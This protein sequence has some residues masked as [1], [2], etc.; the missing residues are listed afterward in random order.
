[1]AIPPFPSQDLAKL[2]LGYLAEEQLMTAYDEFL[3]AS[4]YLDALRN[5]YDRIL[6]TSLKHILAEYRAVKIYVETC[7][8]FALRKKLLQCYNLLEMVKFLIQNVDINKLY[9]QEQTTEKLSFTKN[10]NI[11]PPSNPVQPNPQSTSQ[12]ENSTLDSSVETTSLEDLPGNST[13]K[14]KSIKPFDTETKNSH[15]NI[16]CESKICPVSP[17]NVNTTLLT[18]VK[19]DTS[20]QQGSNNVDL[21]K[22]IKSESV[23]KIEEFNNILDY[24]CK[25]GTEQTSYPVTNNVTNENQRLSTAGTFQDF[26]TGIYSNGS[27][28]VSYKSNIPSDNNAQAP[29]I[30]NASNTY[31]NIGSLTKEELMSK[32]HLVLTVDSSKNAQGFPLITTCSPKITQSKKVNA[33]KREENKIK[34]LSDVI[35]D[36]SYESL[37]GKQKM[38]PVLSNATSTPFQ[39]PTILINGTPAYK[40]NVKSQC[41]A[42]L[43]YTSDEIMAM[44]TIILVPATGTPPSS[45]DSATLAPISV[46]PK[47]L[48]VTSSASQDLLKPLLIDVTS[49]VIEPPVNSSNIPSGEQD[50]QTEQSLIKT[51]ESTE[52]ILK[53][54]ENP[55]STTTTST[56][57][58]ATTPQGVFPH[59]KSSSTPRRNSHVRVLDFTT[60]RRILTETINE[61]SPED[62]DHTEDNEIVQVPCKES[63]VQVDVVQE[64]IINIENTECPKLKS[65][66]AKENKVITKKNWDADIRAAAVCGINTPVKS[67]QKSKYKTKEKAIK[68]KNSDEN[69]ITKKRANK[70]TSKEKKK[71]D[72]SDSNDNIDKDVNKSEQSPLV[73]KANVNIRCDKSIVEE[74]KIK[75]EKNTV[76]DKQ[77]ESKNMTEDKKIV[78]DI[79]PVEDRNVNNFYGSVDRTETPESERIALQNV[80]GAKLNIS[81]LL[82]TPYKQ[83][84]YDIQMDTPK[85]LGTDLPDEPMSEVKIMSIPTPRFLR[86]S[87]EKNSTPSCCY[88]S[89]QTDYSSGGSYY[90]PDDQDFIICTDVPESPLRQEEKIQSN[91]DITSTK[92]PEGDIEKHKESKSGRPVRQC[93]KNVSYKESV[94]TK[95]TPLESSE[96]SCVIN[97]TVENTLDDRT[98]TKSSKD[99]TVKDKRKDTNKS[100]KPVKKI[101]SPIKRET[102]KTFMKIKPRRTTPIK[103]VLGGKTRKTSESSNK[104]KKPNSKERNENLTPASAS[105]PT[106]SRRKSSTPRKLHCT[107][108][109]NSESS[110][111]TSPETAKPKQ[112]KTQ[113]VRAPSRES[114]IEQKPLTWSDDG[115]Q[116][117]TLTQHKTDSVSLTDTDDISKIKEYIETCTTDKSEPKSEGSLHYDLIKRGFDVE[118]AKIIE[119]DLLDSPCSKRD[120][121]VPTESNEIK[122]QVAENITGSGDSYSLKVDDDDDEEIELSIHECNEDTVNYIHYEYNANDKISG[123]E[124]KLKDNYSMEICVDDGVTIRLRATTFNVLLDQDPQ[125]MVNYSYKET[126]MAVSSISNFD[127]LYTPLKDHKAQMYDIFDSTLTSLDTPLKPGSPKSPECERNNI[128]EISLEVEKVEYVEK[129]D[130]KKR[131]RLQSGSSEESINCIKKTKRDTQY[132]LNTTNIQNIDIESVLSKLHGP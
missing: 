17:A 128:T 71:K 77:V 5:E 62:P 63:Q 35:V 90:K 105:I 57:P 82:E 110:N 38:P 109:F 100:K 68:K 92:Q 112:N 42:K 67:T 30:R 28:Q 21:A 123:Q 79:K 20:N 46:D 9:E 26:A 94:P 55:I 111:H 45:T 97:S 1:M 93:R 91:T 7:K 60:P 53:S 124:S 34:I 69:E 126:E 12:I 75:E 8:P 22:C 132:L 15:L 59:R 39:M 41:L 106:K 98:T 119:R 95:V 51:V 2:V 32:G 44:P 29:L 58:K 6:M 31:V 80:I 66:A 104:Q 48:T 130:L 78:E 118:T 25:T 19:N 36:K 86:D 3:Q 16:D 27:V 13:I 10:V 99:A 122:I 73:V 84:L 131:K 56:L 50:I 117:E 18:E 81:D 23:Q 129:T 47:P 88:S 102:P 125:E 85:F 61:Q 14:K 114:D 33:R 37:S 76:E 65:N 70:D 87:N 54:R 103:E 74:K 64:D 127:K 120:T 96:Q 72:K 107:K 108:I 116:D 52:H 24:V 49:P 101:K 40:N 4:P 113:Q 11:V 121:E 115:S 83:V 89:R 43:K